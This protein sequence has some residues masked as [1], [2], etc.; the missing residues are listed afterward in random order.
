MGASDMRT[1]CAATKLHHGAVFVL[2]I[3]L[4]AV[5]FPGCTMAGDT[6]DESGEITVAGSTTVQPVAERIA[7]AFMEENPGAS[8]VVMGG[9]SSVGIK[10][11]ADETVDIG[12]ASRELS[13][14][15]LNLGLVAHI[16]ARDGIAIIVNREQVVN[17]L[18]VDQVMSIYTGAITNWSQTGGPDLAIN[19]IAREEGAGTRAAFEE[20]V[21]G[22]ALITA[23]AVLQP[24]NGAVKTAVTGDPAAIGFVS[25]GYV[26][27]TVRTMS[28]NGV[29]GSI[30]T[31]QNGTYPLVRP[32]LFLTRGQPEGLSK[33]FIAYAL[34]IE[35]QA[36]VEQEG[37]I[38]VPD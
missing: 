26:D 23:R 33:R 11:A 17:S 3:I 36:I 37:Y 10:A 22:E 12:T 15:E 4:T 21:M 27:D 18:T 2:I 24:S 20:M 1:N 35:G 8:V 34:G 32:L 25:F 5:Y 19:V 13:E 7:N 14:G 28:I 38:P 6:N 9:G 31:V 29:A 30:E 16:V